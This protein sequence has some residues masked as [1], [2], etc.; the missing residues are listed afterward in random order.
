MPWNTVVDGRSPNV[1]LGGL[2]QRPDACASCGR[3]AGTDRAA[4]Q[5]LGDFETPGSG[6]EVGDSLRRQPLPLLKGDPAI[7]VSRLDRLGGVCR[8]FCGGLGAFGLF[9]LRDPP[10]DRAK[11][12]GAGSVGDLRRCP[13]AWI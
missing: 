4:D 5:D 9:A 8:G 1:G 6:C 3:L 13:P 10:D 11:V 7:W 12:A 2:E